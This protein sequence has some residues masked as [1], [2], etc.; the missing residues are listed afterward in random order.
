MEPKIK[1]NLTTSMAATFSSSLPSGLREAEL[2]DRQHTYI[3]MLKKVSIWSTVEK[4]D[5]YIV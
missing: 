3:A 2:L 4:I 5:E 1:W